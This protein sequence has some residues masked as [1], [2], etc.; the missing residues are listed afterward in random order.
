MARKKNNTLSFRKSLISLAV[1][2]LVQPL[3]AADQT[4][5]ET[6]T[7]EVKGIR[8]SVMSA[9]A[10]KRDADTFVDSITATDIGALP[11]SSVLESLA[12]V[13]GVSIDQFATPNDPDHFSAQGS[14]AVVRGMSQTRSEFNGRDSFS[15]TSGRGLSFQDVSS[16]M[17]AGVDVYKNQTADMIE[18]GIAGT[19]SLR[20]R[21][22]FDSQGRQVAFTLEGNYGDMAKEWTPTIAGLYSDRWETQS[23]HWGVLVNASRSEITTESHGIQTK[24]Y[25]FYDAQKLIDNGFVPADSALYTY[26]G[27]FA[28]MPD[29][30][31]VGDKGFLIPGGSSVT[32]K[33]DN[34]IRTGFGAAVQWKSLDDNIQAT[35]QFMRSK[36]DSSWKE[37]A[38]KHDAGYNEGFAAPEEGTQWDLDE[39]GIF[40]SGS[41][42]ERREGWRG[43][44]DRVPNIQEFNRF[45]YGV[46]ADGRYNESTNVVDDLS[47]NVKWMVNDNW[48]LEADI[49]HIE[50]TS[51]GLDMQII[52]QSRAIQEYNLNGP[53]DHPV[54]N[55]INPWSYLTEDQIA[56]LQDQYGTDY[57]GDDYFTQTSSYAMH[58]AM[59]FFQKNR[60]QSDAVRLDAKY[61]IDDSIFS[62]VKFGV[63]YAKRDQTI[64]RTQYDWG[65]LQPIWQT[66]GASDPRYAEW[67]QKENFLAG[68]GWLDGYL[69]E[70]AGLANEYQVIDWSDF[71]R[72]DTISISNDNLMIHPSD[73]LLK[74]IHN[75]GERLAPLISNCTDFRMADD[76]TEE[77]IEYAEGDPCQYPNLDGY[78]K[79][80]EVSKT[81]EINTAAYVR[82]DFDTDVAEHRVSGNFGVRVVELESK[83][84]G[85]TVFPTMNA[86]EPAPEGWDPYNY[87]VNDYDLF[88][89]NAKFLGEAYHYLPQEIK[90][91]SNGAYTQNFAKN[92][93][94][95]VLPSF[96][97]K[98]EL[99]DDLLA[100]LAISKAIALPDI[101]DLRNYTSLGPLAFSLD[102]S[103]L[104]PVYSVDNPHPDAPEGSETGYPVDENGEDLEQQRRID[105]STVKFQ[106][107][108]GSAGNPFLKPME[109]NQLDLSL[110][111]YF[112]DDGSVVSSFFYKDLSNFFI[113]GAYNAEFTNPVN[114]I[115]QTARIDG[116]TNGGDGVMKGVELSYNQFY[117]FLP[118]PFDGLGIQA[119]YS[120]IK[121][122]GV[123]NSNLD[124]TDVANTGEAGEAIDI[125]KGKLPLRGQ[126]E[127]TA[128]LI[129]MY[130]K[131]GWTARVAY[132]W[133]SQF[134][135]TSKDVI[136]TLPIYN[137]DEGQLDASLFYQLTDNIKV[138]MQAVNLTAEPTR[139][140]Q[141]VDSNLKLGR[142]WFTKDRRYQ[143]IMRASF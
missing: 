36:A 38:I 12:R 93:T 27:S 23:G 72:G 14:G 83:T 5:E 134:L 67:S 114:G 95:R 75:L 131:N 89:D 6:E 111:W 106:G 78:Y 122:E 64:R 139:T 74:D 32:M 51:E 133:R 20:T 45:G 7:I 117:S 11:D 62:S 142:S 124:N 127:H 136:T 17:M 86:G 99:T 91:F 60:G 26:D 101:G 94:R 22:P 54:L 21:K 100:R 137:G 42:S 71:Y 109:S 68:R 96:N 48:E 3:Y 126:S 82:I 30:V 105:P 123:P 138:G 115:T 4:Q 73:S 132:K 129:G 63:R 24:R 108:G 58:A 50:A 56:T 103:Y 61:Y 69:A 31:E 57:T 52:Y 40:Q 85:Y 128:N 76:R 8:G 92:K 110:E 2:G 102:A 81:S 1:L 90:D 43:D 34:N 80:N 46:S 87:D 118:S 120:Y 113:K 140:Y 104:D 79:D 98:V 70:Y 135:L 15:A 13:P 88:S 107:W 84:S 125:F 143:L 28:D 19:I 25:E 119:N 141:Q 35:M 65:A 18:G 49:Q 9:Q 112:S 33:N 97:M 47:F 29:G 130:E 59:D 53:D 41:L 55:M 66:I 44:G 121:A 16:T 116:P 37:N 39:N 10:I 77:S